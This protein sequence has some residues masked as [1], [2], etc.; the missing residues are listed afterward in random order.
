VVQGCG[1][2]FVISPEGKLLRSYSFNGSDGAT[3]L[4]GVVLDSSGNVFGTTSAGGNYTE[5]CG[6]ASGA[7]CGVVFRWTSSG[8]E[9]VHRF[10]GSPGPWFPNSLLVQDE[11]G[12]LYGT[13][14]W[15]GTHNN[16][17]AAFMISQTGE[18]SWVFSVP[19]RSNPVGGM[20]LLND[21]LYG[22]TSGSGHYGSSF[23]QMSTSGEATDIG[24]VPETPGSLLVADNAGNFYGT[25]Q[26][27]G[28]N[29]SGTVFK[30]SPNGFGGWTYTELYSFCQL[31]NCTDGQRPIRGPLVIDSSGS[32]FGTTSIGG[33]FRNCN[34]EGCGV[35]FELDLDGKETVIHNF[36]GGA[37]GSNPEYGLTMDSAGTLYGTAITGGDLTCPI[38]PPQGCGVVFRM[39]P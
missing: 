37:D 4:A 23:F 9:G 29:N 36:T 6:G 38:N 34:G 18:V 22:G 20:I 14:L 12:N 33:T 7:G 32:I 1:T 27:G 28:S 25:S 24:G 39:T 13:S 31:P 26:S 21:I 3:P 19:G 17:G 16:G 35:V 30:F 2:V 11:S 10:N 15:G 8:K 5:A